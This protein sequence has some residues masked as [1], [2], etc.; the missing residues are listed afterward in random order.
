MGFEQS[1]L[2]DLSKLNSEIS[3]LTNESLQIRNSERVL[4]DVPDSI[5]L[6]LNK[7]LF[8]FLDEKVNCIRAEWEVVKIGEGEA[9]GPINR[10]WRFNR[11]KKGQYFKPHFDAGYVYNDKEQTIF[12]F[13]LYLSEGFEGGETIFYPDD[14]RYSWSKKE[15]GIEVKIKP[16]IGMALIFFQAGNESPRHCGATQLSD[17]VQKHILRSDLAYKMVE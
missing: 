8:P 1:P 14:K 5:G 9:K 4:F 17:E 6:T 16:Q 2:R 12:T 15:E 10:R 3:N 13:I 7:R 11:Y